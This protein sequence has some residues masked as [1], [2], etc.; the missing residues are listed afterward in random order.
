MAR[1]L[2]LD[3]SYT[4]AKNSH[5]IITFSGMIL[6]LM[7]AALSNSF[8]TVRTFNFILYE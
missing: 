1:T 8:R 3:S 4:A 7:F 2:L 6:S 5:D